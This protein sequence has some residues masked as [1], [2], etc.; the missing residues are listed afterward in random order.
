MTLAL[1]E[2][3]MN[4]NGVLHGGILAT[5]MDEATGGVVASVRGLEV[6][7]QAPHATVEMNVSFLAGAR[8]GDELIV[9]AHT[10]RVG[11]SVAFAEAEVRRRGKGDLIA[12]GRFTF[13]ILTLRRG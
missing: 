8:P 6:M 13:A 3:H 4:P 5:L 1:E 9:E 11:R 2:R 12:K 10:L 7:A